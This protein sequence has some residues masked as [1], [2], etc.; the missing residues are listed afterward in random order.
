MSVYKFLSNNNIVYRY[1]YKVFMKVEI[2]IYYSLYV[3]YVMSEISLVS[4]QLLTL[5]T[6]SLNHISGAP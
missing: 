1:K 3:L 6:T 4:E 2:N 5:L